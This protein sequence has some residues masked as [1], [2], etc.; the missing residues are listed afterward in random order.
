[1][2]FL[3]SCLTPEDPGSYCPGLPF[4]VKSGCLINGDFGFSPLM[5]RNT[6]NGVVKLLGVRTKEKSSMKIPICS[7]VS[8]D[9]ISEQLSLNTPK[10]MVI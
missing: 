1:M 6:Y 4:H 10:V 3:D 8:K 9:S 7:P 5:N 2:S